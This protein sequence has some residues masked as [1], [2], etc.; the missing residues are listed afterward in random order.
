M[1]FVLNSYHQS[2]T[3][4]STNEIKTTRQSLCSVNYEIEVINVIDYSLLVYNQPLKKE[5]AKM[6]YLIYSLVTS[7]RNDLYSNQQLQLIQERCT[8]QRLNK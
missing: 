2:C 5:H 8:N 3:S 7:M 6:I 1:S 4:E